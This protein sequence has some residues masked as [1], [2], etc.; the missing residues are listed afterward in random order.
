MAA[1][2]GL[3][4]K[5]RFQEN[6]WSSVFQKLLV[7]V[8]AE[9]PGLIVGQAFSLET[10]MKHLPCAR[11]S[12]SISLFRVFTTHIDS[13]ETSLVSGTLD[14]FT[15]ES[16]VKYSTT[17]V[18]LFLSASAYIKTQKWEIKLH[19]CQSEGCTFA[20]LCIDTITFWQIDVCAK[21]N[22]KLT[23]EPVIFFT[24]SRAN[25]CIYELYI[26]TLTIWS[27]PRAA[28][29]WSGVHSQRFIRASTSAFAYRLP[30][31]Q[32]KQLYEHELIPW[33]AQAPLS[34]CRL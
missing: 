25:Q 9:D 1:T 33:E 22:Q 21:L 23:T 3:L 29:L 31:C 17:S 10:D 14:A 18:R 20:H 6:C 11:R 24:Y 30:I 26:W 16:W 5:K 8:Q 13:R 34:C 4:V 28:A 2:Q 27:C 12:K 15:S 7:S 32:L 19:L